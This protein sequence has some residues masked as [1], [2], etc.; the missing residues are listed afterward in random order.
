M[1]LPEDNRYGTPTT[2]MDQ[3]EAGS[4]GSWEAMYEELARREKAT[5]NSE[6]I[7]PLR[8]LVPTA[9]VHY[10]FEKVYA[11]QGDQESWFR[12]TYR[13]GR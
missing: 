10:A 4:P 1:F 11:N 7:E 13:A 8:I 9:G 2:N 5:G 3:V 12:L 6:V